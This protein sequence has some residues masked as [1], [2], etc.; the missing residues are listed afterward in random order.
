MSQAQTQSVNR[1]TQEIDETK[2][3]NFIGK[4]VGDFGATMESVL[5]FMGDKLGFYKALAKYGPMN[6]EELAGK[7]NTTERYVREWLINQASGGY[8]EYDPTLKKYFLPPEQAVALT[9]EESPYFVGGGFQ[10]VNSLVKA[11]ER[12]CEGFK[13]GKGMLWGEHHHELFEGTERFFRPSYIGNL[14]Q[15]W[16]PSM[17]GVKEKLDRGSNVADIGCGHGASTIIMAKAFPNSKFFGFDNHEPSIKRANEIAMEEGLSDRVKF[18]VSGSADFPDNQYGFIT[19]FDSL[20]DMGDPAAAIKRCKETLAKDGTV[21][22]VEPMA[23]R[24]VEENFNPVGRVYSAASVLCCTPNAIA[25]GGPALGTIAT[26]DKLQEVINAGG[27]SKFKRATENPFN[28]VF[29]AKV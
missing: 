7:T 10:L 17:S 20:H 27:L 23:G 18:F 8:I 13:N 28:R 11:E 29:E 16:I 19:F 21:M 26:D 4:V 6:S 24:T 25:S 15:N 2:L 9:D 1:Q 5:T 3:M 14:I 12:I 22:I